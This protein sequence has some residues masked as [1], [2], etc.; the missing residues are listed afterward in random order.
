MDEGTPNQ[1][2]PG[3]RLDEFFGEDL[4]LKGSGSSEGI[5]PKFACIVAMVSAL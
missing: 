3:V 5:E 4:S 2:L 1:T